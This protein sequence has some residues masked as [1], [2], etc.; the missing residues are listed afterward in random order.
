MPSHSAPSTGSPIRIGFLNP[1][2][3]VGGKECQLAIVVRCVLLAVQ[4]AMIRQVLT[5][6]SQAMR[7][8]FEQAKDCAEALP[9]EWPPFLVVSDVGY[10]I[11]IYADFSGTG[12]N[13]V[14]FTDPIG[15]RFELDSLRDE[16]FRELLRTVWNDPHSLDPAK[17]HGNLRNAWRNSQRALKPA[18]M[19]QKRSLN[20]SCGASSQCLLT[21]LR[22]V[23][24]KKTI[25]PSS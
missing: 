19:R 15:F 24:L 17:K 1:F 6:W 16:E 9:D 4:P 8:A 5:D 10:C 13:Y 12:K 23:D 3:Q 14:Q 20:F 11:D 25:L 21:M 2:Q 7:T 18:A 22:S